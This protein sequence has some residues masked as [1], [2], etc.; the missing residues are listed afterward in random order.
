MFMGVC[1]GD[2]MLLDGTRLRTV[3]FCILI[4][5]LTD[6]SHHANHIALRI[7]HHFSNP[8][9]FSYPLVLWFFFSCQLFTWHLKIRV[10]EVWHRLR[11]ICEKLI[12]SYDIQENLISCQ[13]MLTTSLFERI[14]IEEHRQ[15]LGNLI[16]FISTPFILIYFT[17]DSYENTFILEGFCRFF[18][19]HFTFCFF[20]VF[21]F[22]SNEWMSVGKVQYE[23]LYGCI[24]LWLIAGVGCA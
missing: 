17:F 19:S 20:L 9:T 2:V 13:K 10:K 5:K 1:M 22:G 16:L 11:D 21:V 3:E 24:L 14:K 12:S 15:T 18:F 8:F 6:G 7:H 4:H 23:T